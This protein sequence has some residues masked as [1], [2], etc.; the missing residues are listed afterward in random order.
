[1]ANVRLVAL[2]MLLG[3]LA[4]GQ[5]EK[6]YSADG[7]VRNAQT[8][9]PVQD[10]LVS[11][12]KMPTASQIRDPFSGVPWDP[13][14]QEVLSGPAGEFRFQGLPA[15]LY[16]YEAQK[17]GFAR[18]RGSFTLPEASPDAAVQVNLIPLVNKLDQPIHPLFKIQGKVQGYLAT[19]AVNFYLLRGADRTDPI[20]TLFDVQTGTFEILDVAPGEY[21]LRAAQEKMRGEVQVT[22]G[23]ADVSGI[24]IALLPSTPVLG[25]MLSVG[26]RAEAI[27]YPKPCNVN[28]SQ[29]WSQGRDAVY[30]PEWQQNG[31]FT[32]EGVFPGDYQVR[33]ACFGAYIRSASFGG[34]DLLRNP[35]LTIPADGPLP[36]LEIDYTPGGGALQATF[37]D[38]VLPFDAVLLAPGFHAGNGPE[39]QRVKRFF[40]T[41][42]NQDMFQFSNLAPGDYM[43]YTFPKFE[44]VELGNPAFLRALSGGTRVH[45]EDG[46]I[47]Q[48]TIT[49]TS[50]TATVRQVPL[51]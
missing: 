1:V 46:Q 20:R 14:A 47:T 29:D 13:H 39:L 11:V 12:A 8:A 22:V 27:R 38:P 36:S 23:S 49:G 50:S 7:T 25:V 15:G 21:R 2:G 17:T 5:P 43:L 35:V 45:I 40:G 41:L 3:M 42:P 28:L 10:A 32:L 33:F 18:Y 26:G 44:D 6:E 30:V 48:L 34:A 51:K 4:F 16:V 31:H 19:K 9:E 37:T 24:P